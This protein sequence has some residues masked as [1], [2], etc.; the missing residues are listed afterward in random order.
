MQRSGAHERATSRRDPRGG[1]KAIRTNRAVA[2]L[3]DELRTNQS[4]NVGDVADME[5]K[6]RLGALAVLAVSVTL[7]LPGVAVVQATPA[8]PAAITT[9][10]KVDS[11]IVPL[12]CTDRM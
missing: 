7:A 11:R 5:M 9:P 4:E 1:S 10:A 12:F 3:P 8:I 2:I 6:R